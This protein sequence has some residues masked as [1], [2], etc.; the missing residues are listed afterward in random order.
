MSNPIPDL[1]QFEDFLLHRLESK[2]Y[3]KLCYFVQAALSSELLS[4]EV[5]YVA[6]PSPGSV[7]L[8]SGISG[9]EPNVKRIL[10]RRSQPV[11]IFG[12]EATRV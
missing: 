5:V 6:M 11:M 2:H 9:V 8:E 12:A 10:V 4:T 1:R 7:K 3:N